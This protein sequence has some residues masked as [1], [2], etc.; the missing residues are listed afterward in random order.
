[1]TP[2]EKD[3]VELGVIEFHSEQLNPGLIDRFFAVRDDLTDSA[4][5]VDLWIMDIA[6]VLGE[7]G[8]DMRVYRTPKKAR[9]IQK[10]RSKR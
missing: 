5:I 1:M 3:R 2:K 6:T 7:F 4:S 8:Y 10:A 9:Q